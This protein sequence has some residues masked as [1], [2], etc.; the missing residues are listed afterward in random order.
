MEKQILFQN[1]LMLAPM[2]GISD[3]AYRE[4]ASE[5]GADI[6]YTEMVSAK[7][8]CVN[9]RNTKKMLVI[10]PKEGKVVLQLF[11]SD[12][13]SMGEAAKRVCDTPA[14]AIDINMGCPTPKIV[15]NRDG[16]FLM[17]DLPL[18]GKVIESVVLH[19]QLPVTVKM[20]S[21]WDKE[22][23]N[24]PAL[25][26]IAQESGAS[27]VCVHA[28]TR[29]QFYAPSADW[30]IIRKVK[31]AVSIP[32]IGNGDVALPKDA[33]RIRKETLCDSVMLGRAAW[34]N[35]FLF[36]RTKAFLKDGEDPG[37]PDFAY[38]IETARRHIALIA[39]YKG[40]RTA[41]LES[42]KH[43]SKYLRGVFEGSAIRAKLHTLATLRQVEELLDELK[44]GAEK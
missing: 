2:A 22:T 17:T 24:A 23:V 9:N 15:K 26:K 7:A 1:Q 19:T 41:A 10:G 13:A 43:L 33:E 25:A 6:C 29:D 36:A 32:V 35:P 11:G 28:R 44:D 31:E 30:S 39:E 12:P 34:G 27:A 3:R 5:H 4:V 8:V 16:A 37:E 42:R 38:K 40:E 21:G 14:V 20:R 18:A